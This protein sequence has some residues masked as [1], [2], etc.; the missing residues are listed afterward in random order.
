[1]KKD[2]NKKC[3]GIVL[4][5]NRR[6]SRNN[7]LPIDKG[8]VEGSRKLFNVLKWA[9]E[10]KIT[11]VAAYCFSTENW[12]RSIEEVNAA[13]D[14][15]VEEFKSDKINANVRVLPIGDIARFPENMKKGL[16]VLETKTKD[17]TGLNLW[18][19]LSYGGRWDIINAAKKLIKKGGEIDEDAFYNSLSTK[20]MPFPDLIIRTGGSKRLSNFLIWEAAYSELYFTKTLWPDFSKQEFDEIMEDFK[21]VSVNVGR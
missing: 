4:D 16:K 8:Y 7:N 15:M 10:H 9:A 1:M 18:A 20:G 14:V 5:G 13:L 6:W 21:E 19:L 12:G 2:K 11:D 17:N 3:L